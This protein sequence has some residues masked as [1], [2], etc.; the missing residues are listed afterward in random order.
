MNT[1]GLGL[2]L[3]LSVD[4][5]GAASSRAAIALVR[6]L[7]YSGAALPAWKRDFDPK[8]L[9]VGGARD[10]SA[11]L[12][13]NGLAV[14]WLSA[15]PKGRFTAGS[16]VSEDIDRV[17]AMLRLA[18]RLHAA[19]VTTVLGPIGS[20]DSKPAQVAREAVAALAVQAD[21]A[22]TAVALIPSPGEAI[23]VEAL[24]TGFVDAPIGVL[25]DPGALLFAGKDPVD[26]VEAAPK[27]VAVRAADSS[28][29]EVDLAPGEGRVPWRDFLATLMA[30]DYYGFVTVDF[31]SGADSAARAARAANVLRR[32][33]V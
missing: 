21:A 1:G 3:A 32:L 25:L 30:R 2:A 31:A 14:S 8:A 28:P 27:V 5:V 13:K 11:F 19:A 29:E 6:D 16:A 26:V 23:L 7:G 4:A 18:G 17:S 10:L 24:L 12:D 20:T 22:G 9:G 15:G 33:M